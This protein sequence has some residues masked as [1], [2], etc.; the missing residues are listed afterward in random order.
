MDL[1]ATTLKTAAHNSQA[2][3]P[4]HEQDA[5]APAEF[6]GDSWAFWSEAH[7]GLTAEEELADVSSKKLLGTPK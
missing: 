2:S 7:N 3:A 1:S 5:Q 4:H 6:Y